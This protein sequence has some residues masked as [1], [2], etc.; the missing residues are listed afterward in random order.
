[1]FLLPLKIAAIFA[2]VKIKP[3]IARVLNFLVVEIKVEK[4]TISSF[5]LHSS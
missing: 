3:S 1:V 4:I 5:T 2:L